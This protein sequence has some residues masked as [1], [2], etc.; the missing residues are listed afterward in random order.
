MR[1]AILRSC[2]GSFGREKEASA[3]GYARTFHSRA[4]QARELTDEL[5]NLYEEI[6]E[7][8]RTIDHLFRDRSEDEVGWRLGEIYIERNISLLSS[9]LERAQPDRTL[10]RVDREAQERRADEAERA[11]R[12]FE[13][14]PFFES[15]SAP[16]PVAESDGSSSRTASPSRDET[17]PDGNAYPGSPHQSNA[18]NRSSGLFDAEDDYGPVRKKRAIGGVPETRTATNPSDDWVNDEEKLA[19]D[20]LTASPR[21]PKGTSLQESS[22]APGS[23]AVH[24]GSGELEGTRR[25]L[26]ERER[27][28][29]A[30][31]DY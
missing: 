2:W 27:T 4:G 16:S 9:H 6:R 22:S 5:G 7:R 28:R 26:R 20:P 23:S 25:G 1:L 10:T 14:D 30:G 29:G 24:D 31:L 11:K 13:D 15:L 3:G 19:I 12:A 21:E 8:L 17:S 18:R